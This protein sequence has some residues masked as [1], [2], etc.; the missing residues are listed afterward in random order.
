MDGSRKALDVGVVWSN[1]T[2]AA[3]RAERREFGAVLCLTAQPALL[4]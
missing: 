4:K 1:E 2:P 3:A